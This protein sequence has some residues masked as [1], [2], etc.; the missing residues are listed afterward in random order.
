MD[1][2]EMI[3][4]TGLGIAGFVTGSAFTAPACD[5]VSKDKAVRYAGLAINYLRDILPLVSQ[6]GGT[7]IGELINKA[8]P[9]LEKLKDALSKSEIPTAG[10]FFNTVT[11]ILGQIDNAL[12]QLP[13]SPRRTV[14]MGILALA[15]ITLHTVNLFIE[16]DAPAAAADAG[17]QLRT[18]ASTSAVRKA[19]EASRF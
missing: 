6:L 14:I 15:N 12:F 18:T 1:R 8:L 13:E 7:Q 10:N 2:R 11:S 3:T 9:L 4:T 5:Q 16:S 19:F 17:I